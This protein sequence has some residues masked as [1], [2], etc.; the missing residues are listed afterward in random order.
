MFTNNKPAPKILSSSSQLSYILQSFSIILPPC[1]LTSCTANKSIF[2]LALLHSGSAMCH[3]YRETTHST[4]PL[5]NP[6]SCCVVFVVSVQFSILAVFDTYKF[7]G[8]DFQPHN[9]QPPT[10]RTR[11]SLF[12]WVITFDLSGTWC[13]INSF[14][15]AS[16]ALRII[17]PHKPHHYVKV[18][19][20]SV[21]G[22]GVS[23]LTP[24]CRVLLEKLAGLQ[25]V[26]K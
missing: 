25:L 3:F 1:H 21:G 11:V 20:H 26:K 9:T 18:G 14:T 22:W 15:T 19:I 7:G 4:F 2:I 6:C 8:W 12:V 24:W 13:R 10:W 5:V 23:I 17:W 16:T